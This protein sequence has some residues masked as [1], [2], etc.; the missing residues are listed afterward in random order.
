MVML[1]GPFFYIHLLI[2][3]LAKNEVLIYLNNVFLAVGWVFMYYWWVR[4]GKTDM[5]DFQ[6]HGNF[7]PA[8]KR[9]N[10]D[11]GN[12]VLVFYPCD[13]STPITEIKAHENPELTY[14]GVK[15]I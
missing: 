5:S 2:F 13:K 8:F 12:R 15:D 1:Y 11:K 6:T 10:S 9:V 14:Q 7:R 3:S 4:F